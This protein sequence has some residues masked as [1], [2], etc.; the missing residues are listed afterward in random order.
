MNSSTET[1]SVEV[2]KFAR[3]NRHFRIFSKAM[4]LK[5]HLK[6]FLKWMFKPL[7]FI[8]KSAFYK[9]FRGFVAYFPRLFSDIL[10]VAPQKRLFTQ[11][12]IFAVF[13]LFMSS[14]TPGAQI[15]MM[16]RSYSV[17]YI[18]SYELPGD[19]LVTDDAGYLVKINPQ[20]NE[21]NRI[22]MTDF[23]VHTVE[24][25]ESLSFI[26][27]RYGV[28][29]STIMWENNLGNANSL[30]IGQKL[31]IPPVNGINYKVSSGD[32]LEKIAKKYK[33]EVS[34]I[35]A[36]NNLETEVLRKGQNLFLPGAEPIRPVIVAGAYNVPISNIGAK[37]YARASDSP[38]AGKVF[39][40]PTSGNITQGYR[41]GHYAIDISDTSRP[42]IWAAGPGTIEKVSTGT[43]G[44]GY[45]N[46]II[47]DHGDGLKS[48]YAHMTSVN[49][50]NGQWVNQGD[51]IGIMGNTGRV[52]GRTGIHLHWEVIDNGMKVYPGNY[53]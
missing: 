9:E 50:E 4:I 37:S 34:G 35:I 51:V 25:G 28:K 18:S 44:G 19:I 22:G 27:E 40:F 14:F 53:Y 33:I 42:P 12:A 24:E 46:H 20:T 15:Q 17:D 5:L 45:G 6:D 10:P 49:V 29:S 48:L 16:D 26:A 11:T 52:Y 38:L 21:A 3:R 23:A 8:Y 2:N 1:A 47:I 36:Q 13:V 31:M 39:I 7:S 41:A 32:N 30:R 43:W